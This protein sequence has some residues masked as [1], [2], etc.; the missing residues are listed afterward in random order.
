[1]RLDDRATG[2]AGWSCSHRSIEAQWKQNQVNLAKLG[3]AEREYKPIP[4]PIF[5]PWNGEF[6]V[7]HG[8]LALFFAV[9]EIAAAPCIKWRFS[10]RTLLIATTLIAAVLGLAVAM[11]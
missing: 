8:L 5:G 11:L 7:A 4:R 9:F 10:L 2:N 3:F 1:V 6:C